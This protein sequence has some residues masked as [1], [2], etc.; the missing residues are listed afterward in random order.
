M[1]HR[2]GL[3]LALLSIAACGGGEA[4][5]PAPLPEAPPSEAPPAPA[6]APCD[7]C[8]P[9]APEPAAPSPLR[10]RFLGVGGFALEHGDQTV[11]TAP[12]FTRASMV[13]VSTGL[14]VTADKPAITKGLAD[15]NAAH[16]RAIVSGHAHYDHLLDVPAA[17]GLLPQATL[18]ANRSAKNLLAAYAPDRDAKCSG[19]TAASPLIS[20]SRVVAMDD[21][22]ASTVDYQNCPEK[23]PEGAPL[24]GKWVRVPGSNVR[25]LAVC[26]EHPHQVG[27]IHFAPGDVTE[28]PCTPPSNMNQWREGLPLAFLIDFLDPKTD[29]PTFR[30]FYQ[31]APTN[32]PI[33]LAPPSL[34]KG[35]RV[36]LALLCVGTYQNV[37]DAP[38]KTLNA[39]SPRYAIGGHWE[40]F[41][42]SA[43]EPPQPIPFLDVATW[44]TKARAAL[45]SSGEP[46]AL[47]MNGEAASERATLPQPGDT[48]EIS[49]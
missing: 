45:P 38:T 43:D 16:V 39:L 5:T 44:A 47:V 30:V 35:K 6:P 48:F 23:R 18:Y 32:A 34:M 29:A 17:M 42:R 7:P 19:S 3:A 37:D 10:V 46:R 28:E 13:Q 2:A 25:V 26:S 40:D 11:V 14:P 8:G 21:P 49:P 15:V 1:S 33:G 12:L 4:P 22:A 27:P 9:P 24:E 36:D 31:D 20:R 41:F